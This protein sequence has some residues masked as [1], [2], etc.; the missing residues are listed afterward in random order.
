MA[1]AIGRLSSLA[2]G[3]LKEPGL[4]PD[5]GGLYSGRPRAP[6]PG[7]SDSSRRQGALDGPRARRTLSPSPRR[8]R[9][10]AAASG[11]PASTRSRRATR[12]R[13]AAARSG[14]GGHL[15]G[16]RRGLHRGAPGRLAQR[17]STRAQWRDTLETYVY[18]VFGDLPVAAVDTGLVM[19]V[20]EP[21]WTTKPETASR[22]RG[23]IESGAR[24]GD[25]ARLPHR[26]RT[27]RAGAAIS[28][29][30]CRRA[31]RCAGSS[32]MPRCP[33]P[34]SP[35][36][37]AELREQDGIAR[38]CAGVRDPDGGAHRRGRSARDGPRS[39]STAA[40]WTV[41]AERMKAGTRAPRAAV[42]I[43]ALCR[44]C[45]SCRDPTATSCSP[46]ASAGRP[47]SATWRC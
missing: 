19:K 43:A 36:F 29:T 27:R 39:T 35:A 2:F 24:L 42:A 33:M 3:R 4:Y 15:P 18:P 46:A 7:C 37:M 17:A 10:S 44:S 30:C 38:A 22:V 5:G 23:R 12:T 26:A 41:P 28:R 40:V 16:V 31:S 32:T 11:L 25:G 8:G 6:S 14:E 47:L 21:I 34:R 45:G 20:L 9:R 13:K 1:R